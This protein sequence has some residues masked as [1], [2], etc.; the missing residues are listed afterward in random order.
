MKSSE[1]T[2][3]AILGNRYQVL[4]LPVHVGCSSDAA[5]LR[6]NWNTVPRMAHEAARY[7]RAKPTWSVAEI[8]MKVSRAN[9]KYQ[10]R[11]SCGHV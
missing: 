7:I 11:A 2:A 6:L 8:D 5:A 10:L 3:M 1:Q 9:A 4:V